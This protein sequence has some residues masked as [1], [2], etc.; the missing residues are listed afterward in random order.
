M[1]NLPRK[2]AFFTA[3]LTALLA[4]A[5]IFAGIFIIEKYDHEHINASGHRV[6]AGEDC[7]ICL[8]I[9]IALRLIEAFGR[10]GVSMA[11]TGFIVYGLSSIIKPQRAFC[12][13]NPIALKVKFNC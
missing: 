13:S 2:T 10:L 11:L 9:Q 8:E 4:L 6:P 12:P 5:V 1:A 7:R 3:S